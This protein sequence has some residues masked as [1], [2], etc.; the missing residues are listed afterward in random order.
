MTVVIVHVVVLLQDVKIYRGLFEL[1][2]PI[3]Y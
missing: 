2:R 3:G 1:V